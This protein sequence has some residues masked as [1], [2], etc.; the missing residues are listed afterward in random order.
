MDADKTL[1]GP[2]K[3][4]I[5]VL[6]DAGFLVEVEGLFPPKSVDCYLPDYHVA[7]EAD[8]PMHS[9]AKDRDRDAFL[10]VNYALPVVHLTSDEIAKSSDLLLGIMCRRILEG[11]WGL[12]C[13]ERRLIATKAGALDGNW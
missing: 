13:L 6:E 10:M 8:G 4:L 1:T 3:R 7:V 11:S 9:L 5:R 2:H 12:T